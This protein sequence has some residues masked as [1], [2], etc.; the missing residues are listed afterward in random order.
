MKLKKGL[1]R[2]AGQPTDEVRVLPAPTQEKEEDLT[3][4]IP[5]KSSVSPKNI[6][7]PRIDLSS[8]SL[9]SSQ[10]FHLL[11]EF[12]IL[13][14]T[15]PFPAF[16]VHFLQKFLKQHNSDEVRQLCENSKA[17]AKIKRS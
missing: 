12:I 13:C 1:S 8:G 17:C 4:S 9:P 16:F 11:V 5:S 7:K 6:Q 14:Q 15:W 2:V 10:C 3:N